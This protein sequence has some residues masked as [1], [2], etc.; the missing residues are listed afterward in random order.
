MWLS[1]IRDDL[2]QVEDA[3]RRRFLSK[4]YLSAPNLP[5][6]VSTKAMTTVG[7]FYSL[8]L[9]RY[10]NCLWA[11][12]SA[13]CDCKK[14]KIFFIHRTVTVNIRNA[15][16]AINTAIFFGDHAKINSINI[17]LAIKIIGAKRG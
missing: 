8:D 17:V 13:I 3:S 4:S 9:L 15:F 5:I 16:L 6:L 10:F 11:A 2:Y 12:Y 14:P 1:A 7:Y